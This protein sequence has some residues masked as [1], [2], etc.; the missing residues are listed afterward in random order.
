MGAIQR[1]GIKRVLANQEVIDVLDGAGMS[2]EWLEKILTKELSDTTPNA[3]WLQDGGPDPF[4]GQYKCN[5][6]DLPL[7]EMSDYE[8][9]NEVFLKGD[10]LP[11]MNMVIAGLA[12]MPIVYLTAAKERIRWLSYQ[13]HLLENKE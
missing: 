3:K 2:P 4:D 8:L 1:A 9:A 6:E 12:K 13:L 10:R 7:G 11:D 5:R